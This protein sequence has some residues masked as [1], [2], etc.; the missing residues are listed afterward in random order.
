VDSLP[1]IKR[2][3]ASVCGIDAGGTFTDLVVRDADGTERVWKLPSTPEN[4]ARAVLDGLRAVL[5]RDPSSDVTV[6]HGTTVATNALLERRG[7]RTALV[8]NAGF[9]DVIEIARQNRPEIY[10]LR[11]ERPAPLV[12][13]ELRFGIRSRTLA[14]GEIRDAVSPGELR[15][16]VARLREANVEAVAVS[17]L[18]SYAHP[19]EERR[20]GR[21]LADLGVPVTL[22]SALL[23]VVRE[24][25]RTATTVANAWL[26]PLFARYLDDLG[27]A[28]E[29]ARLRIMQSNGGTFSAARARAEPVHAV[30]SGPAG[31]AL[32]ALR[33]GEAAGFPRVVSLDMG[34]T[35]T[36]VCVLD[37]RVE[38]RS[39][40][41]VGGVPVAV[42]T[43]SVHTV[44]AG[45]GSIAWKDEGGALR[46][47]PRSAGAVPGPAA[48]GRG[49]TAVTLTDAHLVLGTVRADR[50]L[51]GRI[52]LDRDA[53]TAAVDALARELGLG[54][55][56][57]AR[58]VVSVALAHMERALR[59]V[60]VQRGIDPR[61]F[62][63]VAFG[64]AGPLHAVELA[65]RL[66]ME[67][68]L[69]PRD[70]GALSARGMLDAPVVLF[71]QRSV[72]KDAG[73]LAELAAVAAELTA[74]V[75]AA[76][77]REG[78]PAREQGIELT[79]LARY[80]GQAHELEV[81]FGEGLAATFH[82]IHEARNGYAD[83]ARRVE[84]V[85]LR[86]RGSGE[87]R[88]PVRALAPLGTGDG[89]R[90]R[91]GREP[92]VFAPGETDAWLLERARLEPGDV[93][94]GPAVIVEATATTVLPPGSR[95]R[96]D[97]LLNLVLEVR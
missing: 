37:G 57:T 86:A 2:G 30:L 11:I 63:L 27:A 29:G 36:D 9:E 6:I 90:A 92:V 54:R 43:L 13:R 50:F 74:E 1:E 39:R 83:L 4:P 10:A 70:P 8:T 7:A 45:G 48:Y 32:G 66:G 47:G 65:Q 79:A 3:V 21:A 55:L 38:T 40:A 56:E 94:P 69:V 71:S 22:S 75:G 72:H 44:G 97:G 81:P 62:T 68:A 93:V 85:T 76:L 18:H 77:A 12:P 42:P 80:A 64:G 84:V 46:V 33:E 14:S 5:G 60:T 67:R 78:V 73:A 88:A 19:D 20:V 89:S 17:L 34:G 95:A 61:A 82:A 49:G 24:Y 28:L 16:L 51:G 96:V 25:E 58:G 31:G 91:V 87:S 15:D 26:S 52:A 41:E 35:S 23:P 59:V 53:A